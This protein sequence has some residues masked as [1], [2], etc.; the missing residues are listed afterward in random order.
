MLQWL[1]G[2]GAAAF[3]LGYYWRRGSQPVAAGSVVVVTGAS[4]GSAHRCAPLAPDPLPPLSQ[5][6]ALTRRRAKCTVGEH[7]C[8][9]YAKRG[10]RVVLAARRRDRLDVVAATCRHLGAQDVLVVPTDVAKD[11]DC[12]ALVQQTVDAFGGVDVLF[13]NAGVSCILPF[14]EFRDLNEFHRLMDINFFGYVRCVFHALPFLRRRRGR[15]AAVSSLAGKLGPPLRTP[16]SASKF[17]VQ[18]FFNS[19]RC[20]VGDEVQVTLICPGF[21]LSEIH[22]KAKGVRG[23]RAERDAAQ[24]MT[25][26]EC[27]SASVRAVDRGTREEVMTLLGKVGTYLLPFFPALLDR[28]AIRKSYSVIKN[29]EGTPQR[30]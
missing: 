1:A 15:I 14:T 23:G 21:V 3:A 6:P 7:V 16:Y 8:Y 24:F 13:L 10:A 25:A 22:D 30:S 12:K 26:D 5:S 18:G 17:A 2:I 4:S 28:V 20:E 11:A 29:L 27:A 19:L 9:D